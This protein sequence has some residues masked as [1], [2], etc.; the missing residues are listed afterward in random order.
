MLASHPWAAAA[1]VGIPVVRLV[2]RLA[3]V[4]TT[5]ANSVWAENACGPICN[6]YLYVAA[7]ALLHVK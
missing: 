5:L 7:E 1:V 6:P 2:V 3:T 4:A